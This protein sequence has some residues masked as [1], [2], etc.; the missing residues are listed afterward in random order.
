[1]E[2]PVDSLS[3]PAS[4]PMWMEQLQKIH[5]PTNTSPVTAE[6]EAQADANVRAIFEAWR[7]SARYFHLA[8]ID[9]DTGE[10]LSATEA[11]WSIPRSLSRYCLR[12]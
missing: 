9:P 2:L 5:P 7:G 8:L 11:S 4:L 3:P 12:A 10:W 1:M 6:E